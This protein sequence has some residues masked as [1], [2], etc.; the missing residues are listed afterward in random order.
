MK[1]E[2]ASVCVIVLAYGNRTKHLQKVLNAVLQQ[3]VGH[4]IVVANAVIDDT[5][6]L[7][8]DI[9]KNHHERIEIIASDENLGSA[10]GYALGLSSAMKRPFD[11]IWLLDDDNLPQ[12]GSLEALLFAFSFH[13]KKI[14]KNKLALQSFRESLPEMR[15]IRRNRRGPSLPRASSFIGFHIFNLFEMIFQKISVKKQVS[16]PALNADEDA[17]PLHSSP[18]GGLFFHKDAFNTLGLP[19]PL[20]F[21]YADDFAY[22]L[23]FTSRGGTL[24]LIPISRIIDLDP[25]WNA[26][27]GHSINIYRRLNVLSSE[28][29][30]YEVRNRIYV[31]RTMFPGRPMMY[32]F[33]KL[34]YLSLLKVL[35]LYYRQPDRYKLIL[36]AVHDGEQG[37][38]GKRNFNTGT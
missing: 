12:N 10:G 31:S 18:Y 19:D 23:N 2:P 14:K 3:G 26:A 27:G 33:N 21:L 38:L 37:R 7:L 8:A 17:I 1:I 36:Q 20:L 34:I 15:N 6:Q 30:Y 16:D 11:F 29:T 22:T 24:L 9:K 4:I 25:V 28:K 35:A 32:L 13:Q 5:H